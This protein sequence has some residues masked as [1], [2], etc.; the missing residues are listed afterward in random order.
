MFLLT[1]MIH[2]QLFV[3]PLRLDKKIAKT[4]HTVKWSYFDTHP[5]MVSSGAAKYCYQKKKKHARLAR[6]F[7]FAATQLV[8]FH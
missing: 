5:S 1:D 3:I 6:W 4:T 8:G 2:N 7:R